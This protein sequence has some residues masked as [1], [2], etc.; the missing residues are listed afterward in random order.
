MLNPLVYTNSAAP[1]HHAPVTSNCTG[2]MDFKDGKAGVLESLLELG[3]ARSGFTGRCASLGFLDSLS[4]SPVPDC[5]QPPHPM[6]I[7]R[8]LLQQVSPLL[9]HLQYPDI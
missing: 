4:P 1:R 7:H 3:R 9:E 8:L 6:A 2:R 5:A